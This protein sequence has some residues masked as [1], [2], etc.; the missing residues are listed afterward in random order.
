MAKSFSTITFKYQNKVIDNL[1]L[2]VTLFLILLIIGSI[3]SLLMSGLGDFN[4]FLTN[5]EIFAIV[6]FTLTQSILSVL[7]SLLL[8]IFVAKI[9][10]SI[11]SSTLRNFILSFSSVAFVI[12]TVVAG[13]GIIKV[14]GGNGLLNYIEF[15]F[16][17]DDKELVVFGLFGILLAHVFFNAPLFLRVFYSCL[18][19]IPEN[20][21]KNS[22]Q[23]N[24]KGFYYFK[25]IEWPFIKQI[26]PLLCGIVF[27]QCFTSFSIILML[28]GGPSASTLEVAIYTAV[29]YDFDLNSAAKLATIQLCICLIILIILDSF[30]KSKLSNIQIKTITNKYQTPKRKSFLNHLS[31]IL[32]LFI[33]FIFVF[34]PLVLL[35]I[36]GINSE[37][38]SILKNQKTINVFL[39][40]ISIALCSSFLSVLLSWFICEARTNLIIRNELGHNKILLLKFYNFSI[41][42]YLAVPSIVMGTGLFI[43]LKGFLSYSYFP[44][45]ILIFSNVM[46]CLPFTVNII[47]SKSIFLRRKHDLLCSSLGINGV[48]RFFKIDF[49]SLKSVFGVSL[50]ISAC[51]SLGDLSVI[52]LFGSQNF[53]TIPWLIYQYMSSYK[54][55]EASSTSTLLI[56]LCFL[57]F[58]IFSRLIGGKNA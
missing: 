1:G 52:A 46:L 5:K 36:A 51:L 47:Q 48:N 31:S 12:P 3:S 55:N 49:P 57:L 53:Q 13:I 18:D 40:S 19:S 6:Q 42:M 38:I 41:L 25:L 45:L 22:M 14:W 24:L 2:S 34:L 17:F 56:I 7:F 44:V 33:Y 8:G 43:I 23:Y 32:L 10:V 50:G 37:L 35:I 4:T 39:N 26:I 20:Y 15:V 16:G 11:K 28:G 21:L 29:R 9:L 30:Q 27:L 58:F 54:M